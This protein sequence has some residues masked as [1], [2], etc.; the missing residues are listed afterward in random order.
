MDS[1]HPQDYATWEEIGMELRKQT[2]S[3][4]KNIQGRLMTDAMQ[5]HKKTVQPQCS[6]SEFSFPFYCAATAQI[7]SG[8]IHGETKKRRRQAVRQRGRQNKCR[9]VFITGNF[10][11]S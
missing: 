3:S 7:Y 6:S 4:N 1:S 8:K 11:F 5:S 9:V 2:D 10:G